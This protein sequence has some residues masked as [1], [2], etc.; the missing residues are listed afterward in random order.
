M[1]AYYM[2]GYGGSEVMQY[3]KIEEP[4]LRGGQVLV[5][6][7]AVSLNPVDWKIREG[8]TKL[9]TGK[10]FPKILGSDFAGEIIQL[11]EDAT[12][13][14]EGER[15]YGFIPIFLKKQGALT[16]KVVVS[17]SSVRKIPSDWPYEIAAALPVAALTAQNGLRQCGDLAG[18]SILINGGTGGVGHYA[19]Q[20]AVSRG[21]K[22][23]VTCSSGN[24]KI[25]NSLGA[26]RVIDYRERD[27][28]A[29]PEKFDIIF[30]AYGKMKFSDAKKVLVPEGIFTTTL[31]TPTL[32]FK[33]IWHNLWSGQKFLLANFRGRPED[34]Q[35]LEN[36]IENGMV[37]PL[38]GRTFTFDQTHLA[39]EALEKGGVPGKIIVLI[40]NS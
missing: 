39:F 18:K 7:R 14:K 35:S 36:L 30:D 4:S 26:S 21:A 23:T 8:Q 25:A 40:G 27:V 22:V 32:Y 13:C 1:N 34:Y 11:S 19:V 33:K 28:T 37:Q 5:K 16:E 6:V 9:I 10:R 20:I 12:S 29:E 17:V 38:I 31:G 2:T 3:G 15:V 24:F